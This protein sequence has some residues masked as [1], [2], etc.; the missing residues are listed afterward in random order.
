MKGTWVS[1]AVTLCLGT[2]VMFLVAVPRADTGDAARRGT[3]RRRT[4]ASRVTRFSPA[5]PR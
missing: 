1:L 4:T 2:I 3:S 5:L